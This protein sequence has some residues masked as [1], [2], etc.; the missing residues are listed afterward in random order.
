MKTTLNKSYEYEQY[1]QMLGNDPK[2]QL[3]DTMKEVFMFA[4]T[5]G[6][7]CNNKKP[8]DKIGGESIRLGIY[9]D[10]DK[11]IMDVVALYDNNQLDILLNDEEHFNN[12][13]KLIEQY[14][15]GGMEI[16]V[17]NMCDPIPTYESLK[18]FV[19]TFNKDINGTRKE[20]ISDILNGLEL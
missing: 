19:N 4:L 3:F 13:L 9:N 12:K 5:V 16:I 14:A 8:F 18:K 17:Q 2:T 15:N 10:I 11:N 6:F 1:F 7:L 20:D